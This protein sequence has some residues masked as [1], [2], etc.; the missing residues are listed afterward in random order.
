MRIFSSRR[1]PRVPMGLVPSPQGWEMAQVAL[2][3]RGCPQLLG[4]QRTQDLPS[5]VL[6]PGARVVLALPDDRFCHEVVS[7]PHSVAVQDIEFQLGLQ[8][9]ERLPW[10]LA[11]CAWDWLPLS[12][13]GEAH[14]WSCC[15]VPQSE[16]NRWQAWARETGCTLLAVEPAQQALDREARWPWQGPASEDTQAAR[17]AWGLSLRS[18]DDTP[19][20]NLLPHRVLR[21]AQARQRGWRQLGLCLVGLG[22]VLGLGEAALQSRLAEKEAQAALQT[23]ARLAQ[24][25]QAAAWRREQQAWSTAQVQAQERKAQQALRN[26]PLDWVVGSVP[27]TQAGMQWQSVQW[28]PDRL[29]WVGLAAS[30]LL[31]NR[32]RLGL[33]G[34][35]VV[36]R[37]EPVRWSQPGTPGSE[38]AWLY[39]VRFTPAVR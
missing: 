16:I 26:R 9:A 1:E 15:A 14:T 8:L 28:Q 20:F 13:A 35:A 30:E 34:A 39:E 5:A 32:W 37:W 29:T 38:P 22:A 31:F 7:L 18:A 19:G 12:Q 2:D 36:Q 3:A 27:A 33:G 4:R 17:L 21:A 10:P 23:Q 11:E 25:R 6:S 24:E